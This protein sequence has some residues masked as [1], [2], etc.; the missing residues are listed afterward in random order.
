MA[1]ARRVSRPGAGGSSTSTAGSAR[2]C[3]A[4]ASVIIVPSTGGTT[5]SCVFWRGSYIHTPYSGARRLRRGARE[6]LLGAGHDPSLLDAVGT[7][8]S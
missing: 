5:G 4:T 2:G 7:A 6:A 3:S 8:S 1:S